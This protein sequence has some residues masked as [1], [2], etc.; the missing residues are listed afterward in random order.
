MKDIRP[1]RNEADYEWALAEIARYFEHEPLQGT[2]E[3]DRFDVLASLIE[4]YE[5][6]HWPIEAPDPVEAIQAT[7]DWKGL[8]K[9]DLGRVLGS[10]PRA[11]EIL[12]RKRAL[13]MDMA[14]KIHTAFGIPADVLLK[15][16]HLA[17]HHVTGR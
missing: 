12:N 3:A 8:K 17:N 14:Y 9:A 13:T 11:S 6:K 16:Y 7:L 5:A 4:S 10:A 1:L 15:P 2:P